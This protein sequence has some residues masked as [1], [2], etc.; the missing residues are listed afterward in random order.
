MPDKGVWK[1]AKLDKEFVFE[2]LK[3]FKVIGIKNI[4]ML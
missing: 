1:Y 2:M 3:N 4:Y